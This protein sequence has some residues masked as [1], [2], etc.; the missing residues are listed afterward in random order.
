MDI[1]SQKAKILD[2]MF[3]GRSPEPGNP[4]R[5]PHTFKRAC[6]K[7]PGRSIIRKNLRQ[8]IEMQVTLNAGH[9]ATDIAQKIFEC[10]QAWPGDFRPL[11]RGIE[12]RCITACTSRHRI[13]SAQCE[14]RNR[15]ATLPTSIV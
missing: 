1:P 10:L 6:A 4:I 8:P 2:M 9:I 13:R 5:R 12:E 11:T 3:L 7:F 15:R 14:Q